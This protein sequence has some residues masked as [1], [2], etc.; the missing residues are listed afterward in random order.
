MAGAL[1]QVQS[2]R[3]LL[4]SERALVLSSRRLDNIGTL[5][6]QRALR[7]TRQLTRG[8]MAG[9]C[10]W[11]SE[12]KRETVYSRRVACAAA[13]CAAAAV[14]HTRNRLCP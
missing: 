8:R 2:Q 10:A 12:G 9:R 6:P 13:A 7:R 4:C 1:S 3:F 5:H 14:Q 11:R